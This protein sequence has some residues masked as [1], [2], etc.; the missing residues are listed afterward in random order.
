[1]RSNAQQDALNLTILIAN[2]GISIKASG[3]NVAPNCQGAG[4]GITI[5]NRGGRYDYAGLNKCVAK[6]KKASDAFADENQAFITANPG[7]AYEVVIAVMDAL[8]KTADGKE[9]LFDSI[10]F[11]VL[12]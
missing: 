9:V 8:R 1:V 11:K 12:K 5:P 6:L 4:P 2:D 3:G 7:T 10:N